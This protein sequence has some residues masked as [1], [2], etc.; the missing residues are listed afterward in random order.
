M[1]SHRYWCLT[2][3]IVI[4]LL[5]GRHC[6]SFV[7]ERRRS[8]V[9]ATSTSTTGM[10]RKTVRYLLSEPPTSLR[11]VFEDSNDDDETGDDATTLRSMTFSNLRKDQ[12]PQLLCNFLMELG[13][14]STSITDADRGTDQEK[15]IFDE[16][17]AES[18]TRTAVT[19]HVWDHCDVSAHFPASTDLQR[20]MEIVQET[21]DGL[22]KYTVEKVENR[23]WVL[24]V[25]Q[26]WTPIVLPPFVLRFP[27]HT[28]EIVQETVR[29]R[30]IQQI[31]SDE[32]VEE[33]QPSSLVELK[34][35]GGIAFGTGEHPTTQL[36]LEWLSQIV[37]RYPTGMHLVDYGSGSGV[38]GM[39]AC[40]LNPNLTSV[41]VDIDVDA[42]HIANANAEINKVDMTNYLSNLVQTQD[43]ESRSLLLKAYSSREGDI[44]EVL[45]EELN[46]PIYDACVA[47]IL[48]G[49]LVV[50][51]S[52]LAELVRP[53]GHL[54]LSGIMS[55]QSEMILDAYAPYFE[56]LKVDAEVGGWILVTGTRKKD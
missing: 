27:W 49:P 50:L 28:D 7:I 5:N 9:C 42:V 38:L 3:I 2:I 21:F 48:A 1:Y 40:K 10:T 16:F 25:Q 43:G 13:A 41:G 34:L 32:D 19:T 14:C 47:N 24:H 4:A 26:S 53:G 37:P 54:G 23:D 12:E 29:E 36:C 15:A 6:F 17:D 35:Q 22:P 11:T 20:I 52:N 18:M 31:G 33:G 8:D 55:S 46:K 44:A 39:A 51:A 30:Q 56:S 45:P